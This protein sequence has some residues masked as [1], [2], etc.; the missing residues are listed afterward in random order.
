VAGGKGGPEG[1]AN[2]QAT[3]PEKTGDKTLISWLK[4]DMRSWHAALGTVKQHPQD[5]AIVFST[6]ADRIG[7]APN[8]QNP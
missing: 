2:R 7:Q 1:T 3:Q 5:I 6:V 4:S 8:Q